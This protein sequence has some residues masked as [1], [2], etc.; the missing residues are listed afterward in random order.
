LTE[1]PEAGDRLVRA[2]QQAVKLKSSANLSRDLQPQD[3]GLHLNLPFELR[4]LEVSLD[5]A[6]KLLAIEV[7]GV[8]LSAENRMDVLEMDRV[9]KPLLQM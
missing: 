7:R 6:C 2:L 5:E 4:A 9:C 1:E 8:V 3:K